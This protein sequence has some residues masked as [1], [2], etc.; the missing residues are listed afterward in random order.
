MS[1]LD[2]ALAQEILDCKN[3]MQDKKRGA[4]RRTKKLIS[5]L[6]KSNSWSIAIIVQHELDAYKKNNPRAS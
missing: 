6:K 2:P 3:M 5:K 4:V 1:E